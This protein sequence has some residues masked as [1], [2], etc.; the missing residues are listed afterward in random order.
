MNQFTELEL[1]RIKSKVGAYYQ[2]D[3]KKG[4]VACNK[5]TDYEPEEIESYTKTTLNYNDI[6]DLIRSS[7]MGCYHCGRKM[8]L[9]PKDKTDHCRQFTL[10]R[11]KDSTAHRRNNV[12][13]SCL[14]C[15]CRRA[16]LMYKI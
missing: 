2:Q 13:L 4:R 7:G 11:V 6:V 15:N 1:K 8:I 9:I 16:R 14:G 12:V 10:D 5:Y 3:K